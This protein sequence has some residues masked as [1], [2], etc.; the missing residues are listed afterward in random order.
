[1]LPL[2]RRVHPRY[3]VHK[4]VSYHYEDISVL[5]LTVDLGL[6]GMKIKAHNPLPKGASLNFKVI[7]EADAIWLKGSVVYSQLR[8]D[9]EA[10]SGIRF[11]EVSQVDYA[12]LRNYLTNLGEDDHGFPL[13]AMYS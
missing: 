11:K 12:S 13:R 6:G 10:V 9:L 8:S 2:C 5:T 7:L 3:P 4:I 1:M